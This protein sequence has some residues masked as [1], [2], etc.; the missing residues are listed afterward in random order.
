MDEASKEAHNKDL[1]LKVSSGTNGVAAYV[2]SMI[3]HR[4][5]S[6]KSLSGVMA[7]RKDYTGALDEL[8]SMTAS[9]EGQ[10][11]RETLV[12]ATGRWEG[13]ELEYHRPH[14]GRK[15]R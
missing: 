9:A 15:A 3:A 4:R 12:Q 6:E 14:R 1:A 7:L 11:L 8:A 2:G 5:V 10:R 13:P